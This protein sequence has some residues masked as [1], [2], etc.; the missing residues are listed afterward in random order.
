MAAAAVVDMV[1]VPT[2]AGTREQIDLA[3]PVL[4][5]QKL[6]HPQVSVN[7]CSQKYGSQ[8]I[9]S[10]FEKLAERGKS[11]GYEELNLSD[12]RIGDEGCAYL[13]AGLS[14]NENIKRLLMP[15]AGVGTKGFQALGPLLAS[16]PALEMVVLSGNRCD[17]DGVGGEFS[18]GLEKNKT[19]RSL[20]LAECR[21]GDQGVANLCNGP[22]RAHPA[23]EHISLNYNRLE[24]A[25]VSSLCKVLATNQ[26]LR[27]LDLCGN[28]IGAE[29]AEAL[30]EGL[31]ANKGRLQKLG[32]A[33]NCMGLKGTKALAVHFQSKEGAA[34]D[35]LDLRHNL[36][37]YRGMVEVRAMLGQPMSDDPTEGPGW[38][39]L[40]GE[41]QLCLNA[42]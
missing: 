40:F 41:R 17:A 19:L 39:L 13:Q 31:R 29:G 20:F 32:V 27:Y 18:K 37:T 21:L 9:R 2:S 42:H 36:T 26:A 28:S 33:Q 14:G 10:L 24:V 12:N 5:F 7:A 4:N 23:L 8:A 1:S 22:L 11:C 34:L 30:V 38:L 3:S 6:S 15:R 25:S 35:F 16:T